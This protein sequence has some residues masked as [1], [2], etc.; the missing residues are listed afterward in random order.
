VATEHGGRGYNDPIFAYDVS[1]DGQDATFVAERI[2]IPQTI[3]HT[4]SGL[5]RLKLG[6]Q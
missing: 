6:E 1:E 5:L 4:A 2:A 3:C